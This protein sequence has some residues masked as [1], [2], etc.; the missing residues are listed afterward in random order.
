MINKEQILKN[1]PSNMGDQSHVNH[2]GC[3][4]GV[5]TK[6][7]LYIKRVEKGLL[8]YC[9]HCNQSGFA[10]DTTHRLSSWLVKRESSNKNNSKPIIAAL[11]TEGKVWLRNSFCVAEDTAHFNGIVGERSKVALTLYNQQAEPIG[12]Q[13]RNLHT[14]IGPKYLTHYVNSSSKGDPN[15]FCKASNVLVITEDY[16]SSYRIHKDT[17]CSAVAL[18][19]TNLSDKTLMQ[20]HEINYQTILIWLDPDEA[21]KEAAAKIY[22]KLTHF[23]PTTTT[24]AIYGMDK[25]PKECTPAELKNI[26]A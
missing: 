21:G 11:T 15:W 19:G 6:R 25:E 23:L 24:I 9:H 2:I 14:N 4:A 16:L 26:L 10:G 8:A 1:A 20:I 12:W 13:V 17:P 3:E 22:K 7:R 18:L 5:D